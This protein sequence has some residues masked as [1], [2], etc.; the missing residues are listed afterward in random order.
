MANKF[1]LVRLDRFDYVL[2]A[3]SKSEEKAKE[4]VINKYI[5]TYI[6]WNGIDPREDQSDYCQDETALD[7]AMNDLSVIEIEDGVCE[8]L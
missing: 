7:S 6:K 8:W 5:D 1:Y 4:A 2:T 3:V